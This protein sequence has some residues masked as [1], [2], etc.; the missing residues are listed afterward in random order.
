MVLRFL[1]TFGL[2]F[3]GPASW[4]F[5]GTFRELIWDSRLSTYL[6]QLG[7]NYDEIDKA[8]GEV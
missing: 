5:E 6:L 3:Y 4:E 2:Y 7:L 8:V 1:A